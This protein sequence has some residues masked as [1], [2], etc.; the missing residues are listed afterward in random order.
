MNCPPQAVHA[1]LGT[2]RQNTW[3]ASSCPSYVGAE[4]QKEDPCWL[5]VYAIWSAEGG[6][7][8][9]SARR[10]IGSFSE[11][12]EDVVT[13]FSMLYW[14]SSST[15]RYFIRKAPLLLRRE[16]GLLLEGGV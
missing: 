15:S 4:L 13:L 10:K 6:G 1:V 5:L 3:Q 2:D 7:G 12:L 14:P 11:I 16:V 9:S 8:G